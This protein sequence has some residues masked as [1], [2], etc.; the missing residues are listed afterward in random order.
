V[1]LAVY[2]QAFIAIACY[3]FSS[4]EQ[5]TTGLKVAGSTTWIAI[6]ITSLLFLFDAPPGQNLIGLGRLRVLLALSTISLG[7]AYLYIYRDSEAHRFAPLSHA[8]EETRPEKDPVFKKRNRLYDIIMS[9][10][11][12][13]TVLGLVAEVVIFCVCVARLSGPTTVRA[14]QFCGFADVAMKPAEGLAWCILSLVFPFSMPFFPFFMIAVWKTDAITSWRQHVRNKRLTG[15]IGKAAYWGYA[16]ALCGLTERFIHGDPATL[17]P[18]N[19]EL[20]WSFGQILA[21][22]M[23]LP[24]F[25]SIFIHLGRMPWYPMPDF[26]PS[27]SR[28]TFYLQLLLNCTLSLGKLIVDSGRWKHLREF[29]RLSE[30]AF[31]YKEHAL[32]IEAGNTPSEIKQ[33]RKKICK[34]RG[35]IRAYVLT[36]HRERLSDELDDLESKS[37][38]LPAQ[39]LY[40]DSVLH[41]L[42]P[43]EPATKVKK[44]KSFPSISL[45]IEL[46]VSAQRG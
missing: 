35:E 25:L 43:E 11:Y 1:R 9:P 44:V 17:I 41:T 45:G 32:W 30:T 46:K 42:I 38:L 15:F 2:L 10:I 12:V 37:N 33:R 20:E 19:Q 36:G 39:L 29:V 5:F 4:T 6:A 8:A 21:I 13:L 24:V 7:P 26:Q 23:L 34:I 3:S 16:S 31:L 28:L 40:M 18:G 14:A 22:I 27:N